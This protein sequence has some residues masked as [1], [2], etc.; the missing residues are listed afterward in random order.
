MS[1]MDVHALVSV[2][3]KC[4]GD[5]CRMFAELGGTP[6][7]GFYSSAS[8]CTICKYYD[9]F[10]IAY[11]FV[12]V[13]VV[14]MADDGEILT[15]SGPYVGDHNL[16][17]YSYDDMKLNIPMQV[18]EREIALLTSLSRRF[19]RATTLPRSIMCNSHFIE[20]DP[21][22]IFMSRGD[23]LLNFGNEKSYVFSDERVSGMKNGKLG[24]I[25]MCAGDMVVRIAHKYMTLSDSKSRKIHKV[26]WVD[27][28]ESW[29]NKTF[30]ELA[31]IM[32]IKIMFFLTRE[33]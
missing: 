4:G 23:I 20:L 5:H 6:H 14:S 21:Y 25:L 15:S 33:N 28:T 10:I 9:R 12:E 31:T 2:L 26:I 24:D 8:G 18:S 7:Q 30:A 1:S 16:I 19:I 13:V 32:S 11:D 27:F 29:L 17:F 22:G 3:R